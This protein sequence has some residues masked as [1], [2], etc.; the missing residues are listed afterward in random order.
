MA[1]KIVAANWKMNLQKA[2]ALSLYSDLEND[3]GS[4][5]ESVE[6]VVFPPSIYLSGILELNNSTIHVGAQNFYFEEKGAFT[7]EISAEQ[8]KELGCSYVLVGHSERREVFGEREDVLLK[9]IKAALRAGLNIIYCIGETLGE[10]EKGE[11]KVKMQS[12][13]GLLSSF[14]ESEL[15]KISIAY[16]P[17]WAIGTGLTA[18][19]IQAEEMHAF[20]REVLL[21]LFSDHSAEKMSILY[22]GSCNE[23]NAVELFKCS[24]IDGGLIGGASLKSDSFSKIVS[25]FE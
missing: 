13:I 19:P 14:N 16:E 2:E 8:L 20:I 1:K 15:S 25:S 21:N 10:R 23:K 11:H 7:G 18:T 12:Q 6:V 4:V 9:K 24:N 17:I 22:G 3:L 5:D